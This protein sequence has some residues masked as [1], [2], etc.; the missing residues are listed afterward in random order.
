M[1]TIVLHT[2]QWTNNTGWFKITVRVSVAY[3]FQTVNKITLHKE[4][5]SVTQK[6]F[7]TCRQEAPKLPNITNAT[8]HLTLHFSLNFSNGTRVFQSPYS[9]VMM[10]YPPWY[11]KRCFITEYQSPKVTALSDGGSF[12]YWVHF[13]ITLSYSV[14]SFILL[15]PVWKL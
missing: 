12:P 9:A 15:L 14:S 7:I 10:I 6:V 5:E 1:F 2:Q 11:V 4:Y 3:N 8:R 13:W